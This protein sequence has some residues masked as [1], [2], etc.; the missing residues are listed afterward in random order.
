MKN[1]QFPAGQPAVRIHS[2]LTNNSSGRKRLMHVSNGRSF[3]RKINKRAQP[4]GN[5]YDG[6]GIV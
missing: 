1:L 3:G 5:N 2:H 4:S 6:P